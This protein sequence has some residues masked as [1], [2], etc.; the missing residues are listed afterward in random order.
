MKLLG[1][2]SG[3]SLKRWLKPP[4]LGSW[5]ELQYAKVLMNVDSSV[6]GQGLVGFRCGRGTDGGIEGFFHFFG[7]RTLPERGVRRRSS[8]YSFF[9]DGK[10]SL[11]ENWEERV[12]GLR[13][14]F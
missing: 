6:S 9:S 11:N 8:S 4:E 1:Y 3:V 7:G 13:T 10:D 12:V 5:G 14:S 2:V